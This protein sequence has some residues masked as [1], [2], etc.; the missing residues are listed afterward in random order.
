MD[1][2][3]QSPLYI[4]ILHNYIGHTYH[5]SLKAVSL[6]RP[7]PSFWTNESIQFHPISFRT[8]LLFIF[9]VFT[10]AAAA[11][12][13]V[14]AAILLLLPMLL[15]ILHRISYHTAVPRAAKSYILLLTGPFK[16]SGIHRRTH[17]HNTYNTLIPYVIFPTNSSL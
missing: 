5:T 13:V 16:T 10:A 12:D 14:A 7:P 6:N 8:Y 3:T 9:G 15:T 17:I 4:H 1:G 2:H 11:A